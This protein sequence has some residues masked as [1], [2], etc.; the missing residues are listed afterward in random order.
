MRII[1]PIV[2][3]HISD[4]IAKG[5]IC[6]LVRKNGKVIVIDKSEVDLLAIAK[7]EQMVA[8]IEEKMDKYVKV[9]M[10]SEKDQLLIM[11]DFIE[12][13]AEKSVKREL[14]NALKRKSPIRNFLREVEGGDLGLN[15]H[16]INFN[17]KERQ[18]W[19]SNFLIDAYN[20]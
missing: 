7:Q 12:Q 9:E 19:V 20:Y 1:M 18:R 2:I 11:A 5:N 17:N 10:V 15:Q 14:T 6:Y 13:V 16:W 4:Q 8:E 3:K